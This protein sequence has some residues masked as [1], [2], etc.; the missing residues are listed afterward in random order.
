MPMPIDSVVPGLDVLADLE[1]VARLPETV[2]PELWIVM[3][4][5]RPPS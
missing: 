3:P 5:D 1:S 2:Q 4:L